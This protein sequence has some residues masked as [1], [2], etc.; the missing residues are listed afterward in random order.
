MDGISEV[1][2]RISNKWMRRRGDFKLIGHVRGVPMY[3]A[4]NEHV[5]EREFSD[6]LAFARGLEMYF[7]SY[8]EV[9]LANVRHELKHVDQ[10]VLGGVRMWLDYLWESWRVGYCKNKYER[11]AVRA[12]RRST[13]SAAELRRALALAVC[14]AAS[15]QPGSSRARRAPSPARDLEAAA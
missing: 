11:A 1:V 12:E 7:R 5:R 15:A 2:S 13:L 9:T 10:Y 3:V 6:C 4:K 8:A 14:H